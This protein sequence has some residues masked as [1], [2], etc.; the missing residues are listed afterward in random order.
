MAAPATSDP[1]CRPVAD[2][3]ALRVR[4]TPKS[5]R[6]AVAGSEAT[7]EGLALK[8]HVRA[9]PEDGR[10]NAALEALVA[11]WLGVAKGTVA[12]TSGAKSRIKRVTVTG[13]AGALA[14]KVAALLAMTR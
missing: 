8:A 2:G 4:L 10:A 12:V 6:D 7:A 5:S 14:A 1:L 3:V 11:N 13:D 9:V